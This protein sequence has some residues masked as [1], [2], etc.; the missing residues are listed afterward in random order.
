MTEHNR[1]VIRK[2]TGDVEFA[3]E[4]EILDQLNRGQARAGDF[5]FDRTGA[6]WSRLGEHPLSEKMFAEKPPQPPE[7]RL[8]YIRSPGNEGLIVGPFSLKEL[9]ARARDYCGLH[10]V[11]VDGDKEWR[12]WKTVKPLADLLVVVPVEPP[13]ASA[14]SSLLPAEPSALELKE[15]SNPSIIL[16]GEESSSIAST[17]KTLSSGAIA[18]EPHIEREEATLAISTLGLAMKEEMTAP[19]LRRPPPPI[20]TIKTA[21]EPK[22]AAPLPVLE[23]PEAQ[24]KDQSPGPVDSVAAKALEESF[25]GITAELSNDPVWLVKMGNSDA[26]AGPFRFLEVVKFLEQG[27]INKND[28]ISR[29]GSNRFVKILQ[30]YEFNVKFS[31]EQVMEKGVERQKIFIRRRHPRVPY[32]TDL[33]I[34]SKHGQQVGSCVNISAGGILI[35]VPKTDFNLGEIIEVKVLPALIPRSVSCRAQII[36]KVPKIPPGYALKFEDLKAEDKEAIEHFIQDYL[37]REQGFKS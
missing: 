35:E 30:Q 26:V 36:G 9:K 18:D 25:D 13:A 21:P 10:W 16:E 33:Q 1:F 31:V 19:N 29:S 22:V 32:I 11:W 23:L 4:Q 5:L 8:V 28:K 34:L 37:R 2:A 6:A 15:N 20:P 17:K 7:R 14:D 24:T 12:Q 3:S 27:K